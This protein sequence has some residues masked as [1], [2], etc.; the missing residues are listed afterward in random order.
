MKKM[1]ILLLLLT[2]CVGKGV[3]DP[4]D[5]NWDVDEISVTGIEIKDMRTEYEIEINYDVLIMPT[6]R[7][8]VSVFPR[9]ATNKDIVYS[10]DDSDNAGINEYGFVYVERA[11]TY[12][13]TVT[14]V[15]GGF[16]DSIEITVSDHYINNPPYISGLMDHV[17]LIGDEKP[18]F[19][20]GVSVLDDLEAI[21]TSEIEIDDSDVEWNQIGTY[22]VYFSVSDS[23]G[24]SHKD[25]KEIKIKES[26]LSIPADVIEMLKEITD[27]ID[28]L[29]LIES[30]NNN[31]LEIDDWEVGIH[32]N[33][34]NRVLN[35]V[36][37][38][39]YVLEE[40]S[41]VENYDIQNYNN[42]FSTTVTELGNDRFLIEVDGQIDDEPATWK[43]ILK[44]HL[45]G[46]RNHIRVSTVNTDY[47]YE[48]K[49]N[50][51]RI[52]SIT[53]AN[54]T[55]PISVTK[56]SIEDGISYW[57][58]GDESKRSAYLDDEFDYYYQKNDEFMRVTVYD[59][60][61]VMLDYECI[62]D[63]R[64]YYISTDYLENNYYEYYNSVF[65]SDNYITLDRN[66]CSIINDNGIDTVLCSQKEFLV[67]EEMID[68]F[69]EGLKNNIDYLMSNGSSFLGYHFTNV[70]FEDI[71]KYINDENW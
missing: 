42:E 40:I 61:E 17:I 54:L 27:S 66:I 43:I 11:G 12:L 52:S 62:N 46:Y 44:T 4:I 1:I 36:I 70:D 33:N 19:L 21:S 34:Y 57:I 7:V 26:G 10:I 16:Q 55:T 31:Y 29:S 37:N 18:D 49:I 48:V 8:G 15:D 25:V 30:F 20:A 56:L 68:L 63:E 51:N 67:F 38:H 69:G 13:I 59:A 64:R 32:Q 23:G 50:D 3:A 2:S 6:I 53:H 24:L 39:L 41:L 5:T 58:V 14:S 35:D 60:M 71:A 9:N 65:M 22:N 45:S 28:E 47:F